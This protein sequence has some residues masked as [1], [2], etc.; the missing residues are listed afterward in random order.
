VIQQ[1]LIVSMQASQVVFK[2]GDIAAGRES[3]LTS[4]IQLQG[5]N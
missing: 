1:G 3:V 5:V 2:K 4:L